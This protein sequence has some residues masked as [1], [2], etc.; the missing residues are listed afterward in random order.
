VARAP[1]G[2]SRSV[3]KDEVADQPPERKVPAGRGRP[4]VLT[5]EDILEAAKS[6]F[7]KTGYA[8][9]TLDDLA[10]QL[11]TGKGTLYYHSN[12]KVDLLI[13]ISTTAVGDSAAKLHK[14]EA[15]KVPPQHRL[16]LA[17]RVLMHDVI[18]DRQATKVYFENESDLPPKFR[19]DMR[20]RLREVQ[21][22]FVE[23]VREGVAIGVFS[24]DPEIVAKHILSVCAWPYRWFSRDGA[25]SLDAFVDSAVRF[26]L[27]GVLAHPQADRV[28]E[29]A[30]ASPTGREAPAPRTLRRARSKT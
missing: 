25:L 18:S 21:N 4:A 29:A 24:G 27:G 16:A 26:V 22:V 17:M 9:T 7:S 2:G 28:I 19:A 20:R 11:N 14:I 5:R 12:R 1:R 23:I 15:L 6:A 10:D 8:N 30:L 13:A 3:S